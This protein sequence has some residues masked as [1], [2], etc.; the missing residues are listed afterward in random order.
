MK[1]TNQLRGFELFLS[2]VIPLGDMFV[3]G[4]MNHY[5]PSIKPNELFLVQIQILIKYEK[6]LIKKNSKFEPN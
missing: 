1:Y 6:Y 3:K 5:N 4:M 2:E